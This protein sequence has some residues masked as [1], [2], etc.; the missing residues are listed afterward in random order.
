MPSRM[1][2]LT[3]VVIALT[4]LFAAAAQAQVGAALLFSTQQRENTF[5]LSNRNYIFADGTTDR[6]L[7]NRDF[8]LR[9]HEVSGW[10]DLAPDADNSP[11]IGFKYDH[12]ALNGS[13]AILPRR[14]VDTA[15]AVGGNIGQ[16]EDWKIDV[17]GG[18]G[19]AGTAPFRDRDAVYALG[20]VVVT[21]QLDQQTQLS[22][23]LSYNGNRSILPDVPLPA[24]AWTRYENEQLQ[25]TLGFPFSRLTWRPNEQVVVNAAYTLPFSLDI[26]AE[27]MLNEQFS[28]YGSFENH[29]DA[30]TPQPRG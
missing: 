12:F 2:G 16:Y 8:D 17:V 7:G 21:K 11:V 13:D 18:I 3:I 29:F 9:I 19:Y 14:M 10:L 20:D 6:G 5:A 27:Y 30:F 26:N 22:F 1:N 4:S 15:V 23:L 24:V 28:L 25:Y